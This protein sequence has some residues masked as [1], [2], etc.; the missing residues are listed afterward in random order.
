MLK[1]LIINNTKT[2]KFKLLLILLA[3]TTLTSYHENKRLIEGKTMHIF[4]VNQLIIQF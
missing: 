2:I 3:L 4:G 1:K